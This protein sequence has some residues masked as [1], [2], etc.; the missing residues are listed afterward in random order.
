MFDSV[1][2]LKR[3]I[4]Y[5][6][7]YKNKTFV[8]KIGGKILQR[9]DILDELAADITMLH[10]VGIHIAVVHGGG[11]QATE[12]C[13]K[14]GIEPQIVAGRRI[15]DENVLEVAKMVYAGK[16]NID[17]LNALQSHGP[18]AVGISGVD[19][20]L[21]IAHRREKKKIQPTPNEEAVEVD[22]GY[23]GDIERVNISFLDYLLRGDLIPVI[24]SLATDGRGT[25]YNVNADTVAEQIARALAADKLLILT[26]TDGVLEDPKDPSTLISYTDIEEISR[27]CGQGKISG[28]M[29]PKVD[30]CI[31]ALKGGV[32]RTHILNGTRNGA[33]L[34]EVFTNA[35][36]GTMIVDHFEHQSYMQKELPLRR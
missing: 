29:L 7:L 11:P 2:H 17:I 25:I 12:L 27:M 28:G 34:V 1:A 6:Q 30:A 20:N 5:I 3:A 9:Q 18:S 31:R 26:D 19:G 32:R 24:S 21:L 8:V 14:L 13:S 22:F 4:P 15:T 33:L 36:C 23:V 35:G 16:L 10:H